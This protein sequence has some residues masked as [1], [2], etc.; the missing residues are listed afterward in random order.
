MKIR[1]LFGDHLFVYILQLMLINI[2]KFWNVHQNIYIQFRSNLFIL[3]ID[4]WM[5]DQVKIEVCA[6]CV[7]WSREGK[8]A[9]FMNERGRVARGCTGSSHPLGASDVEPSLLACLLRRSMRPNSQGFTSNGLCA[10]ATSHSFGQENSCSHFVG[11]FISL[12]TRDRETFLAITLKYIW[13]L[14][15]H[16]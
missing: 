1:F 11:A 7:D 14:S 10:P 5:R 16:V 4:Q 12:Y 3:I 6:S 9:E 15:Q 13:F 2:H 8:R